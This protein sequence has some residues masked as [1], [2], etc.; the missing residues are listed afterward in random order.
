[1][2]EFISNHKFVNEVEYA[3]NSGFEI[4]AESGVLF[5]FDWMP[6]LWIVIASHL[7]RLATEYQWQMNNLNL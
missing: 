1:M 2:N 5:L 3:L 4:L 7:L 6:D